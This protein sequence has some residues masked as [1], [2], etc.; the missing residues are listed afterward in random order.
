M[1][2]ETLTMVDGVLVAVGSLLSSTGNAFSHGDGQT[3]LRTCLRPMVLMVVVKERNVIGI[4]TF[5]NSF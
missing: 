4:A 5:F 3:I 1:G 2:E